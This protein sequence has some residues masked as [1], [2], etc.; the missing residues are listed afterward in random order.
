MLHFLA[1]IK[2]VDA[3]NQAVIISTWLDGHDVLHRSIEDSGVTREWRMGLPADINDFN[4]RAWT[5]LNGL[6]TGMLASGAYK[7]ELV[8][9]NDALPPELLAELIDF[10]PSMYQPTDHTVRH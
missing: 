1:T 6:A 7:I 2:F 4:E 10:T 3:D 9:C 8:L 5:A